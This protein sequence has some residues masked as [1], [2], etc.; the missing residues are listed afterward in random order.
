MGP[1]V[2]YECLEAK[3][4]MHINEDHFLVELINPDTGEPVMYGD[5]G[6]LVFTTLTKQA[7]PLIRY[8]TRDIT[9][10]TDSP[11][12]CGRSF[13]RMQRISGR[14][15]DMIII[16]GVNVFPSQIEAVL[17]SSKGVLPHYQLIVDRQKNLDTLEVLVEV[18]KE[19]FSDEVK[20]LQLLSKKLEDEIKSF[21]GVS[22]KVKLVEAKSLE[23]SE[24]KSSRVIDRRVLT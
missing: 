6:E 7:M 22:C 17:V 13:C 20:R 11:C 1:G 5:K 10:I 12:I 2:A 4:G 16:R 15:D 24:G 8:R 18:E 23:R 21:I 19:L 14:T 3:S 9:T